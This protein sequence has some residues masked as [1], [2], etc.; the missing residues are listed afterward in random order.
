MQSYAI[1]KA[2]DLAAVK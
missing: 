2:D 1:S